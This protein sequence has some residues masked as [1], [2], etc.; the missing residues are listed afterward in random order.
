MSNQEL[1]SV[2]SVHNPGVDIYAHLAHHHAMETNI[3]PDTMSEDKAFEFHERCHRDID[4]GH[5]WLPF[6]IPHYHIG[7]GETLNAPYNGGDA[8]TEQQQ[9]EAEMAQSAYN[10]DILRA[11]DIAQM[12]CY[13][14]LKGAIVASLRSSAELDDPEE[15]FNISE[16]LFEVWFRYTNR[17]RI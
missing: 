15:F 6:Q 9:R 5:S 1:I 7:V 10:S 12:E 14:D 11:I 4:D 8:W 16:A 17:F 3:T 13:E 2:A